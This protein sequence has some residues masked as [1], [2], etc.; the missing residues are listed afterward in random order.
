[1]EVC[2]I[3]HAN[4]KQISQPK[5][6]ICWLQRCFFFSFDDSSYELWPVHLTVKNCWWP[7]IYSWMSAPT[8]KTWMFFSSKLLWKSLEKRR[9]V[10][11]F[12]FQFQQEVQGNKK[13]RIIP[14][15]LYKVKAGSGMKSSVCFLLFL[16]LIRR[17]ILISRWVYPG[18]LVTS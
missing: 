6:C 12:H 16:F 10:W 13:A 4:L 2:G 7:M 17:V 18:A 11:P 3:S 14:E 5:F 1:M 15:Y 9:T 8:S